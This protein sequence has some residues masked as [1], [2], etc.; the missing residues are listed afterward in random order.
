MAHREKMIRD[1]QQTFSDI[2]DS[3]EFAEWLLKEIEEGLAEADD[4]N[5]EW[6]SHEE[7]QRDGQ[8]LRQTL[9]ELVKKKHAGE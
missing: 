5:A 3:P 6:V 4:P 2:D 8:K 9:I 1:L 7:I